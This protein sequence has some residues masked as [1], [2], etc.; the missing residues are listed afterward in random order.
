MSVQSLYQKATRAYLLTQHVSAS[1]SCIKAINLLNTS[2]SSNHSSLRRLIYVLF[3][4][5]ATS[6]AESKD[7]PTTFRILGLQG[8][9][10]E[11]LMNAVWSKVL[12]GYAGQ[13][14][15]VDGSVIA[16]W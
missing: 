6:L 16:V 13:A 9:T 15:N 3:V 10:K 8:K 7:L 2:E 11:D 5:I 12:E 4:N 1:H 14:G